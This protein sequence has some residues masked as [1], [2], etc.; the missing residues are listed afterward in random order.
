MKIRLIL[1]AMTMLSALAPTLAYPA[2][3]IPLP[4]PVMAGGTGLDELLARRRSMREYAPAPLK[5]ADIARLLWAAQGTTG[6][7]RRTAPSAGALYPLEI[8]VI[9]RDV[10]DL[11]P[12]VYRYLSEKH[13]LA[14]VS[15]S[16]P[17]QAVAAISG[18][19]WLAQAPAV[20]AVSA[21]PARTTGK[22]G[23]RAERY[24]YIEAGHAAQNLLL[25]AVN[26]GLCASPVGA[27]DDAALVQL[28]HLAKGEV[29]IYL[30]PAGPCA[31]Q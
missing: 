14:R 18:Q 23:E 4:A 28:L 3:N 31:K 10:A 27:F 20:F 9:A 24:V 6:D 5:L 15:G 25:Q 29:P 2:E 30:L 7:K 19:K 17:R 11:N 12:G 1:L 26:L 16:D 13:Q 8:Y 22:Y 21:F